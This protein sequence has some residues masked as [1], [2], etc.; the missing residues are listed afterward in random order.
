MKNILITGASGGIGSEIASVFANSNNRLFL[1]YHSNLKEIKSLKKK[2]FHKCEIYVLKCD[3]TDDKQIV[4]MVDGIIA[5]HKKID[6]LINCAGIAQSKLIQDV[7]E[8]DYYSVMDTNLKS[9]IMT[10]SHVAKYMIAEKY[11]KIVNIS[12]MWGAVGSSMES[13]Y[14][15][16]KG[17]INAFTLSLAKEL[18]P[19]NIN[20]NAVCPGLINTKM[21]K[22]LDF[23]SITEIINATPIQ[24]IGEPKDV[25]NLVK[26][27][28]NDKSNFITGQIIRV[29]GGFTL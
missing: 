12:S 2:L 26:F 3:L 6:I 9:T 20:V 21:N 14:S 24:R 13:V 23:E 28:C 8:Q 10:T 25:A 7:T 16:S 11:G 1:V 5:K 22:S 18:G 15:A 4:E 29:D 17:G 27:L 19:S